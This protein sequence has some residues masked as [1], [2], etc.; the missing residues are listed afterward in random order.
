MLKYSSGFEVSHSIKNC[1]VSIK[2]TNGAKVNDMKYYAQTSLEENPYHIILH[3]GTNDV[4]SNQNC[5][6][7]AQKIIE[8]TKSLKAD[9]R[10]VQI[11]NIITQKKTSLKINPNRLTTNSKNYVKEIIY[12]T[13]FI[14][15]QSEEI[16]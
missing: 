9:Q 7:I 13:L 15:I 6:T 10:D 16:I 3:V 12:T 1:N 5:N 2:S 4:S 8:T 14:G 11:S